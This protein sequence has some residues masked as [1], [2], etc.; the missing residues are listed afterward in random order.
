[1][2]NVTDVY[3]NF[4]H[5]H[6]LYKH[7]VSKESC[8]RHHVNYNLKNNNRSKKKPKTYKFICKTQNYP[9]L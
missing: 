7:D 5:R 4:S 2:R 6:S 1:M 9:D 8:F 3:L